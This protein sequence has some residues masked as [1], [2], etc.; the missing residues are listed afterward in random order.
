ME[1]LLANLDLILC[2]V[3]VIIAAVVFA[4]RGQ[5]DL[6]RELVLSLTDGIDTA[7]LYEKLPAVTKLLI[8]DKTV[9]RIVKESGADV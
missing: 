9:E 5:I 7:E 8:S 3:V 6:L 2:S 1:L 4:R